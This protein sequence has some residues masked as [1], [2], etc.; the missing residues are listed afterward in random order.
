MILRIRN[1]NIV[2]D[3]DNIIAY[4]AGDFPYQERV[5]EL[6][7]DIIPAVEEFI[8]NVNSGSLKPKKAVKA[9]EKILKDYNYLN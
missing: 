6:G 5:I 1:G 8:A 4:M 7:S 2:D 9:F 3:Q